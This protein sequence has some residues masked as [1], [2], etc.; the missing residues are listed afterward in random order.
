MGRYLEVNS[1][2]KIPD[3][4][5][6]VYQDKRFDIEFQLLTDVLCFP[7]FCDSFPASNLLSF[8]FFSMFS[9]NCFFR[10]LVGHTVYLWPFR[11]VLGKRVKTPLVF[12]RIVQNYQ[13]KDTK[14][15]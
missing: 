14:L 3:V 4:R 8:Y 11:S 13:K 6:L 5:Y 15:C 7:N 9:V 2:A 10:F 12:V 1:I